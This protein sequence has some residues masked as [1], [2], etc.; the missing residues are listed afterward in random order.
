MVYLTRPGSVALLQTYRGELI[1]C[2]TASKKAVDAICLGV[3]GN[4]CFGL[5]GVNG[6]TVHLCAV[7]NFALPLY[8]QW[9]LRTYVNGSPL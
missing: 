2:Y 1:N 6:N 3:G 7:Y 9:S 8:I 4:E 5:L